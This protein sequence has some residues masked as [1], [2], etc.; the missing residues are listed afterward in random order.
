MTAAICSKDRGAD[1][2]S[3]SVDGDEAMNGVET[4]TADDDAV[5]YHAACNYTR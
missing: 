3:D 2:D 5:A 4:E 1:E